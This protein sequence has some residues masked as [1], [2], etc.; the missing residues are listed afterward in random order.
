MQATI[1]HLGQLEIKPDNSNEAYALYWW[2]KNNVVNGVIGADCLCTLPFELPP[3]TPLPLKDPAQAHAPQ[4][5]G[6]TDFR[7]SVTETGLYDNRDG[8]SLRVRCYR[9]VNY[10]GLEVLNG[11][12]TTYAKMRP[13]VATQF[14]MALLHNAQDA[15]KERDNG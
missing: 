9:G 13:E 10:I 6:A 14:G 8:H 12:K 11:A 2:R 4:R 7:I 5:P 1:N 3:G 15:L